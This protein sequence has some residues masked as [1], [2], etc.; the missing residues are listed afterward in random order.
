MELII[1]EHGKSFGKAHQ[2]RIADLKSV[3]KSL[4]SRQDAETL[5]ALADA[6]LGLQSFPG[7]A[8]TLR[9]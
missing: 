9:A 1:E 8:Q 2:A 3:L 4:P 6:L 5:L 7:L